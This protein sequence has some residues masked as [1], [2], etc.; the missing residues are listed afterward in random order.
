MSDSSETRRKTTSRC[1]R[2]RVDACIRSGVHST[3]YK[4]WDPQLKMDVALRV[5]WHAPQTALANMVPRLLE[6]VRVGG[7]RFAEV[8]HAG[9]EA[10]VLYVA[11]RFIPGERIARR[12]ASGPLAEDVA[13]TCMR[14][15]RAM[16]YTHYD[17]GGIDEE[18]W[19]GITRFKKGFSGWIEEFPGMYELPL[20]KVKY[21]LFRMAKK[22]RR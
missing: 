14:D 3:D 6:A 1:G 4:A 19:P 5:F 2:F 9:L 8:V 17:L 16:G 21:G 10:G 18:R 11:S 7:P 20:N 12:L 22:V 13:I 15:A